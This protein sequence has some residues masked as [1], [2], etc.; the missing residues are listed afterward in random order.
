MIMILFAFDSVH[1]LDIYSEV[2]TELLA[3]NSLRYFNLP[4]KKW[5]IIIFISNKSSQVNSV[6]GINLI[7]INLT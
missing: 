3:M 2:I 7:W 4:L 5:V 6:L 1:F